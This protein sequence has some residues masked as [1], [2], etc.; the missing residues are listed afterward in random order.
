MPLRPVG[1]GTVKKHWTGRGNAKKHEMIEVARTKG[2][3]PVD[4]NH[5]DALAILSY[6]R[7]HEA[8]IVAAPEPRTSLLKMRMIQTERRDI[9]SRLEDWVR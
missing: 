9:G 2:F 4:D 7:H 8:L 1:V 3:H 6:A 5:A